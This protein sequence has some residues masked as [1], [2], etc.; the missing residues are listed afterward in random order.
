MYDDE[1]EGG[2]AACW[3]AQLC[4]ECGAVLEDRSGPCWRC[5]LRPEDATG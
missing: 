5:G 4:P 1:D 2:D 3:L